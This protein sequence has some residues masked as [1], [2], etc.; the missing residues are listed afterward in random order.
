MD[1]GPIHRVALGAIVILVAT[2][3]S[4]PKGGPAI[5]RALAFA[6]VIGYLVYMLVA[7]LWPH[8]RADAEK[9]VGVV[10]D[11]DLWDRD[12]DG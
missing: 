7:M 2:W 4:G 9:E 10:R 1:I 11:L 8:R 3:Q 5:G 12:L 6:V